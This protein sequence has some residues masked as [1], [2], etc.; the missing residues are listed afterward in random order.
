MLINRR[1]LLLG[2]A[3]AAT[4]A[5]GTGGYAFAI[6]PYR[7]ELAHYALSPPQWQGGPDLRIVALA[8]MHICE[9]WMPLD[10]VR[11]IVAAA[12]A[13]RPDLV[14]L[15]GDFVTHH[16]FVRGQVP[17]EAWTAALA[18]LEAPLGRYA[19]LGNHDWWE[20]IRWQYAR[21]GPTRVG[22]AL[23]AARIPVLENDSVRMV[24]NGKPFWLSGL[25]DQW[26]F[27][28]Y[29]KP[30][31]EFVWG[32]RRED[33]Q[34]FGFQGVDD[35][36]KTAAQLTDDAPAI[37]L[38]HEPDIFPE[39]PARYAVTLAGHTHG[40]QVQLLGWAPKIPSKFGTRYR[41]GH[42]VEADANGIE[43]SLIVSAGL[44]CSGVPLRFGSPPELVVLD[45][46]PP[47][48]ARISA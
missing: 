20:D 44:G 9:P 25:G 31:G 47:R 43:R 24:A 23:K 12:N 13:L 17:Y 8:D 19:I 48:V 11:Q 22:E 30:N 38:I 35:L 29:Q 28:L 27:W 3:S 16:R 42:I 2:A 18:E 7:L 33:H 46:S 41:H 14:V 45:L 4:L 21:Q 10:R 40:G 34:S 39:V 32:R 1:H 5:A 15:L 6:E 37:L 36:P 26:A